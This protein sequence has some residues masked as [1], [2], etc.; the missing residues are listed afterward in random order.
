MKNEITFAV[1]NF[2]I[3][4]PW[5]IS[6]VGFTIIGLLAYW[7]FPSLSNSVL[8]EAG[9]ARILTIFVIA[10]SLFS[11]IL[12]ITIKRESLRDRREGLF[13][14]L[15]TLWISVFLILIEIVRGEPYYL[16]SIPDF[17]NPFTRFAIIL[18][19]FGVLYLLKTTYS[20][21]TIDNIQFQKKE[22]VFEQKNPKNWGIKSINEQ[23]SQSDKEIY[24]PIIILADETTRPWKILLRFILSGLSYKSI[25]KK[26]KKSDTVK[27]S[28]EKNNNPGAI[29]FTF[30][31]PASEIKEM[32]EVELKRMKEENISI[33]NILGGDVDLDNIIF[34]DCYSLNAEKELWNK[35]SIRNKKLK[36]E[37]LFYANSYDPHEINKQYEKALNEL[38]N[39]GCN[40]IRVAYDAISDFLTFTDFQ[41]AT[42]Y[43]RH[44]MGFEQ[45]RGIQSLY[46]FR[47]GTMEKEKE[48]YFLW[49]ANGVLQMKRKIIDPGKKEIID[50]EFR[51]PFREPRKFMIDY[52]YDLYPPAVTHS[53]K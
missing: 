29:Y 10:N 18:W 24:F 8:D 19:T 30:T 7:Y 11:L 40:N 17:P 14:S 9:I 1:K 28:S 48:E 41:I 12:P 44:N 49:F 37:N 6:L 20:T 35:K 51:G 27:I 46:L 21:L 26:S 53:S 34:V 36:K 47:I 22:L 2:P 3:Y 38:K 39:K 5:V 43:L 50:V 13:V 45:R 25:Q 16:Y 32:L 42:Q 31:R 15:F 33:A 23:L 52:R 4:R